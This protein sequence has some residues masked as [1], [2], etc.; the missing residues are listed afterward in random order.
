MPTYSYVISYQ[1][2]AVVNLSISANARSSISTTVLFEISVCHL[3]QSH[4]YD[5]S[6]LM[7]TF[8]ILVVMSYAGCNCCG[9]ETW[10]GCHWYSHHSKC[11]NHFQN[12]M[13]SG[14]LLF[15]AIQYRVCARSKVYTINLLATY[16]YYAPL[17]LSM[18]NTDTTR[19]NRDRRW[20]SMLT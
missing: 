10:Q 5:T 18:I 17:T 1:P 16:R 8:W 2:L 3:Q 9:T 19:R 12:V 15:N 6:A 14:W 11:R 4:M 13:T 7:F 20:Q